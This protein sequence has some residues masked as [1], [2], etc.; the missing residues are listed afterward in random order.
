[1]NDTMPRVQRPAIRPDRPIPILTY[2]QI[3]SA[4]PRG[5]RF[6]GLYVSPASF[7][8]Q[9]ATLRLL[10]YQ[11]LSMAQLMPYLRGERTGRV[12]GITFDDGYVNNLT[13][14]LP[15][16]QRHGFSSTCYAVSQLL[17]KSNVW[18]ADQGV[19]PSPL[20]TAQELRR[21]AE[22]GQEIGAHG[23]THVRLS[24]Q[25]PDTC[26]QEILGS[27]RELETLTG[28]RVRHF[29]FPYGDFGPEPLSVLR[30]SVHDSATTTQRGRCRPGDDP[31]LLPRVPV[32]RTTS[33]PLFLLKVMT[34]YENRRRS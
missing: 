29:C 33:L 34:S 3:A 13:H 10:G 5:T 16:L 6:R 20:M 24:G 32:L 28:Q 17:G 18:D 25:S 31:L 2:H 4:P 30:T 27:S 7:A 21:W 15:V 11:G 12:V 9:M 26:Q 8:R 23:R 1:M 19:P 22:G 14:A